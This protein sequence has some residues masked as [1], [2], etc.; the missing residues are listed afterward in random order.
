MDR[1][2]SLRQKVELDFDPSDPQNFVSVV[3]PAY[4]AAKYLAETLDCILKQTI[5]A[6]EVIVVNDGS[7]DDTASIAR[8]FGK[9]VTLIE[10]PNQG[11]PRTRNWGAARAVSNW[12]AFCD[13][14]D[15]WLPQKLEKQLRLA[16]ECPEV[17]CVI[18]DYTHYCDGVA[19]ERSQFSYAPEGF[20]NPEP[21]RS[22]FVVRQPITGKLTTFQPGGASVP[23][24]KRTFFN[25]V[26]GFDPRAWQEA[27]DT[28]F[29][30]RCLSAVP[31]GVVPEVLMLYRRHPGALSADRNKQMRKT[32][33]V[34]EYIIAEYPQAQPWKKELL[35]G[36]T[37]L[38]KELREN[39]RHERRQ[40]IKKILRRLHLW[41]A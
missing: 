11:L 30:I 21:C 28:C 16:N 25:Q 2:S 10:T 17:Q 24:V 34:W 19:A 38:R 27:E 9:A 14:D 26:G 32:V 33:S 39:V 40:E 7:T 4:N 13:S 37:L 20:W 41:Q 1:A 35:A 29:H 6:A 31:F 22:G 36:L 3:V 5:P 18:T 15:L 8:S 23:M 12:F